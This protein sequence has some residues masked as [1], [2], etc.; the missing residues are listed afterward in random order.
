MVF[1][2]KE[3]WQPHHH[4]INKL[5]WVV[6][7]LVIILIIL[8]KPAFIGYR[9]SQEFKDIEM[10]PSEVLARITGYKSDLKVTETKLD[11]C[12]TASDK[13][14]DDLALEKDE[15]F[16][17][18]Q[19]KDELESD[20]G[21]QIKQ[22]NLELKSVDESADQRI[23]DEVSLIEVQLSNANL[24]TEALERNYED[25]VRNSANN[26]CCK[27]KVDNQDID[28][29]IV[30]SNKVVCTTGEDKRISC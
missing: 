4:H 24:A 14:I 25:V 26:I 15:S 16:T 11:A 1:R 10:T 5:L 19:V 6:M 23:I 21:Q 29:Y 17:C 18:N 28:S 9:M 22:L 20:Y 27:A 13:L 30:S 3:E 12:T 2:K 8:S 7:G